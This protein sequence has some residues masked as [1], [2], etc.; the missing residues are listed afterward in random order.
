MTDHTDTVTGGPDVG[1]WVLNL[2]LVVAAAYTLGVHRLS[3]RGHHWPVTRSM[4]A[5]AGLCC[6]AL[7]VLPPLA[8]T[9]FAGHVIQHLLM[10]MVAPLLLALSAPVTLVLRV[11]PVKTRRLL[12]TTLHSRGAL[13][14]MTAPVVLVL[15]VGGAYA[16]YLT[17]LYD[18]AHQQPWVQGLVDLHMFLAGCLFSWYLIGRDPISHRP[19]LPAALIVLLLAAAS[20]DLLAK[21]LYAKQ[22]PTTAGMPDQIHL[23][24]QIMYY[25]GNVI[26]LLLATLVMTGWYQRSGRRLKQ[27]QRTQVR[28]LSKPLTASAGRVLPPPENR[29]RLPHQNHGIPT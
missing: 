24:A 6:L 14:L 7:A 5:A 23:G 25:G 20:H 26:E 15:N 28:K 4:A 17:P 18:I 2:L 10:A 11:A 21:L 8:G 22:I 29:R 27:E 3:V 12:V 16:Y 9:G 19:S 1:F 13:V